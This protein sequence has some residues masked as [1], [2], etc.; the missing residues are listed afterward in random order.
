MNKNKFLTALMAGTMIMGS[1]LP[2]F[3][4]VTEDQSV[5]QTEAESGTTRPTEVLY[6]QTSTFSVTIPKTIVLGDTKTSDYDVKV[7]GDISSDQQV[8]VAPA[9]S[10]NMEDQATV[11]TKKADVEATVTQ[12]ETVWSSAEVC[13]DNGTTKQGNVSA[14]GLTSGSWAGIFEFSIALENVE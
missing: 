12:A 1:T 10:F 5:G 11:G 2:V 3:A 13:T 8:K 6:T 7:S 14:L 4:A 9:T